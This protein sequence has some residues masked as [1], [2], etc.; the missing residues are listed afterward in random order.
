LRFPDF[1]E[2]IAFIRY[3][4]IGGLPLLYGDLIRIGGGN[5][6]SIVSSSSW[7]LLPI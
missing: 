7:G 6:K 1:S 5:L 4:P 3:K 2:G